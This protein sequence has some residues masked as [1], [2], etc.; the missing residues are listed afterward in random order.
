MCVCVRGGQ[1]SRSGGPGQSN[2]ASKEGMW[3]C[4]LGL[5]VGAWLCPAPEGG[6][7]LQGLGQHLGPDVLHAVAAQVHLG[8]AGVA[9]QGI[10]EDAGAKLQ[11]RVRH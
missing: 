8:Q 6:V 4:G 2:E 1:G 5:Q 11:P 3:G 10:D 7:D 9:A